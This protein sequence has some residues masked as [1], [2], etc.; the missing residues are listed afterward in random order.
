MTLRGLSDARRSVA[1]LESSV[2]HSSV[3]TDAKNNRFI[4]NQ[5]FIFCFLLFL[6]N[7]IVFYERKIKSNP[8]FKLLIIKYL[9]L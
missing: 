3:M 4:Y 9:Y 8:K 7:Q 2:G 1:D 5:L 6:F